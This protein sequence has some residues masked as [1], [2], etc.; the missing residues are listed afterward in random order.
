MEQVTTRSPEETRSFAEKFA[1]SLS[2]GTVICLEGELG[3]GKTT[4]VQGLAKGLGIKDFVTSPSFIIISEHKGKLP[5]YHIDL[6]RLSDGAEV[7]D[8]GIEDCFE[9]G[10]I[11]VIEWAEKLGDVRP[12]KYTSIKIEPISDNERRFLMDK[13]PQQ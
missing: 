5:L 13:E 1:G 9:S 3:S 11:T 7:E 4:F 10:G 8:L 2:P 6:Y 12:K